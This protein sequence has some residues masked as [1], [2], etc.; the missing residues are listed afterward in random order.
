MFYSV[1]N[2]ICCNSHCTFSLNI[3]LFNN[4]CTGF[5]L[6]TLLDENRFPSIVARCIKKYEAWE[7]AGT[8]FMLIILKIVAKLKKKVYADSFLPLLAKF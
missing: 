6:R 5:K 3:F 2:L 7:K 4:R 1:E 8:D